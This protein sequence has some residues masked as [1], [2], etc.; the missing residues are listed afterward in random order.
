VLGSCEVRQR[1]G[2]SNGTNYG[3]SEIEK[4]GKVGEQISIDLAGLVWVGKSRYYP[5][6][7]VDRCSR[8]CWCQVQG[9]MPS[10]K[11]TFRFAIS[12]VKRK[13]G[14]VIGNVLTDNAMQFSSSKWDCLWKAHGVTCS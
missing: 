9:T 12:V 11:N 2:R 14:I 4:T 1:Y 10:G 13:G 6:G 8:Y 3:V 5:I 7:K